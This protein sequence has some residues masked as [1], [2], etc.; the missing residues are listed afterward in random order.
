M[1]ARATSPRPS[2]VRIDGYIARRDRPAHRSQGAGQRRAGGRCRRLL[3]RGAREDHPFRRPARGR[4]PR[5]RHVVRHGVR[6]VP[7]RLRRTGTDSRG[8][9]G[10]GRRQPRAP[11]QSR[12][13]LRARTGL[14]ARVVQPGPATGST[15][16]PNRER[17]DGAGRRRHRAPRWESVRAGRLGHG[18]TDS[19][20]PPDGV[21]RERSGG[22]HRDRDAADDGHTRR[23]RRSLGRRRWR[24]AAPALRAIRLRGS[25]RRQSA[26]V[27]SRHHSVS[28]SGGRRPGGV[29]RRGFPRDLA[30]D[31]GNTRALTRNDA[32]RV[33]TRRRAS[34]R[35]SLACH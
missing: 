2:G 20:R 27:W 9:R 6:R 22:S 24:R 30:V 31:G 26:H 10:Q 11:R 34:C 5:C 33:P 32:G 4:H 17:G 18:A 7:R 28:R 1:D 23:A 19:H 12:R 14:A 21:A 3:T 8:A 16:A 15:P 29:V 25:P 35:S 13:A